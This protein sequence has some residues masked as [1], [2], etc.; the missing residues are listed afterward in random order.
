MNPGIYYVA[1]FLLYGIEIWLSALGINISVVFG[2]IGTIAG[3]S[4]SFFIPSWVFCAGLKMFGSEEE[5]RKQ[6]CWYTIS[7]L[8]FVLGIGF[9]GVF[10]YADIA[11]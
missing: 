7:I 11:Q 8:N 4:L 1:T 6:S 3:T 10:L 9:F 2:Y 5:R